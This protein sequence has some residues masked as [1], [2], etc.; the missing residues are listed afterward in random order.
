MINRIAARLRRDISVLLNSTWRFL[1]F[2]LNLIGRRLARAKGFIPRTCPDC[3]SFRVVI[4]R[5]PLDE[6]L[7]A[8]RRAARTCLRRLAQKAL[9]NIAFKVAPATSGTLT[10]PSTCA[11]VCVCVC[12]SRTYVS[13]V[14]NCALGQQFQPPR[15]RAT[16]VGT[17]KRFRE[18]SNQLLAAARI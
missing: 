6:K 9:N 14:R 1:T 5:F 18:I 2:G 15:V 4:S 7:I 17:W 13:H 16:S 8:R 11:C 10:K 12:M 3:A